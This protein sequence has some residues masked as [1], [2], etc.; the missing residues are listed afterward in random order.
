MIEAIKSLS[1][2]HKVKT[3]GIRFSYS[4]PEQ[5]WLDRTMIRIIER[6]SGQPILSGF[7][8]TGQPIRR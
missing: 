8:A 1:A 6:F 4:R 3:A 7:T 2:P 5:R